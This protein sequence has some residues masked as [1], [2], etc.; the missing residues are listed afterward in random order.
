MD[1]FDKQWWLQVGV[2]EETCPIGSEF[3]HICDLATFGGTTAD[4][5]AG[6][7]SWYW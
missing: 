4:A 7:S 5:L 1:D 6:G 3:M 2:S